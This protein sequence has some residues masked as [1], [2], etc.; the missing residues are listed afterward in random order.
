M[1]NE[2]W[3]LLIQ[4]LKLSSRF[5]WQG[6][7]EHCAHRKHI[8]APTP[9]ELI[10]T[11]RIPLRL[12]TPF[13]VQHT[14]HLIMA[15]I[16]LNVH[17]QCIHFESKCVV[18]PALSSQQ[19][20]NLK[21]WAQ[22]SSALALL[23]LSVYWFTVLWGRINMEGL[24]RLEKLMIIILSN[25]EEWNLFIP[26]TK[27]HLFKCLSGDGWKYIYMSISLTLTNVTASWKERVENACVSCF[28]H[29]WL[30]CFGN[31]DLHYNLTKLS[32]LNEHYSY[33]KISLI[34]RFKKKKSFIC[35]VVVLSYQGDYEAN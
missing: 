3:T 26:G 29:H 9:A 35:V 16:N 12:D 30:D 23:L 13:F 31:S 27:W 8:Q 10:M 25:Q 34:Y 1:W 33:T 7:Q 22:S 28:N 15:F 14:L 11:T 6:H 2:V 21:R 24:V 20:L 4:S 32:S 18:I 19:C 5:S 17:W